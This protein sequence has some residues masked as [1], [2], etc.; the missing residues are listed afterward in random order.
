[1]KGIKR[2]T[3]VLTIL[4]IVFCNFVATVSAGEYDEYQDSVIM[5]GTT[6]ELT[7]ERYGD[8]VT[9]SGTG[10]GF[11]VGVPGEKVQYIATCNHVVSEPEGIYCLITDKATGEILAFEMVS[12]VD[13]PSKFAEKFNGVD[14]N[15][16]VDKFTSRTVEIKAFYSG[17]TNDYVTMT[18]AQADADA[19]VAICKIASE[20]TDKLSALPIMAKED[21]ESG[22]AV[23][24]FGFPGM[25]AAFDAEKKFESSDSAVRP[26]V[27]SQPLRVDSAVEANQNT[28]IEAYQ[29]TAQTAQGMSGG[30]VV[31]EENGA[32]IGVV[33]FSITDTSQYKADDYAISIEYVRALLDK[34]GIEY[35][36]GGSGISLL[37]I[38]LI[39]VALLV[40]AGVV[41]LIIVLKGKKN[42]AVSG[43][44][45][46][47]A[48]MGG[49]GYPYD[50]GM[51]GVAPT[52]AVHKNYLI[53]LSG[54]MAGQ[55]FSIETR[56][57]IGRDKTKCNVV[58]P[59]SQP[60]IS[61]I[62]CEIKIEGGVMVLKD[63]GSSYG[64][65]LYN[66]TKLE[67]NVPVVL[68]SGD[69]FWIGTKENLFEVKY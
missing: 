12:G 10:S 59:V 61:G 52:A 20:P 19:D 45:D 46:G 22:R 5:I 63:C 16:V 65:F 34:E 69:Q 21:I 68:N 31:D 57:I 35:K 9:I 29:I 13:Y 2:I 15:W 39:V 8:V 6:V 37:L 44:F 32:L 14:A 23:V 30:P 25:V 64:T 54:H 48:P 66:G 41:V 62:H 49:A 26:G 24:A 67:P 27:I 53:G 43:A 28:K 55:K 42:K 38:I 60:G 4:V 40:V 7:S 58:Y 47:G 3:A 1:M 18:I 50:A 51:G 11:G 36:I 56:A 17:S 33:A